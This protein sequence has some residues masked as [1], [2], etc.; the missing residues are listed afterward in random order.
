MIH[1]LMIS[2]LPVF[3]QGMEQLLGAET[4]LVIVG[5]ET[6]PE[7]A[8]ERIHEL[9]PDVVIVESAA[10]EWTGKELVLRVLNA[11][12]GTRVIGLNLEDNCIEIYHEERRMVSGL[13]DLVQAVRGNS[14]SPIPDH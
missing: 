5:R 12:P 2:D 8:L 9:A 3:S 4:G 13:A 6:D 1:I 7:R 11:R 14:A 10:P